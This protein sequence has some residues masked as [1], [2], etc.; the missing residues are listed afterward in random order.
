MKRF[1]FEILFFLSMLLLNSVYHYQDGHFTP[2]GGLIFASILLVTQLIACAAHH[3]Y[4]E[5][6]K[7][8]ST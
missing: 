2:S 7:R 3:F 6:K 5:Y 8:I 4:K 1:K